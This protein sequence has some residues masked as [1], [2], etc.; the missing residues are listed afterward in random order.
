MCLCAS[1][2][3]PY[4]IK[5]QE[6]IILR[7]FVEEVFQVVLNIFTLIMLL[8]DRPRSAVVILAAGWD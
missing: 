8:S 7:Y 4:N 2:F 3:N 5:V 6:L 1:G